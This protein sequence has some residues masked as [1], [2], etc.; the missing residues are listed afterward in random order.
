MA[1]AKRDALDGSVSPTA[2]TTMDMPFTEHVKASSTK[3]GDDRRAA[4]GTWENTNDVNETASLKLVIET[5]AG[6]EK[7][8]LEPKFIDDRNFAAPFD[9]APHTKS[10]CYL[11]VVRVG[12]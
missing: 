12:G 7:I 9:P 1:V 6:D 3:P 2:G 8:D 11:D 4:E 5:R 10:F